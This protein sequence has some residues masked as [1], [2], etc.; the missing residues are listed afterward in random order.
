MW[1]GSLG[2][3]QQ[4]L[5]TQRK[6]Q[7]KYLNKLSNSDGFLL[8]E[9]FKFPSEKEKTNRSQTALAWSSP[10]MCISICSFSLHLSSWQIQSPA[11]LFC[12]EDVLTNP[13]QWPKCVSTLC[14]ESYCAT[15]KG[16]VSSCIFA[17]DNILP[18]FSYF[19][20]FSNLFSWDQTWLLDNFLLENL[21]E[22]NFSV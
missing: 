10:R 8:H 22:I 13:F 5:K 16:D 4:L 15:W 19:T 2:N 12:D 21:T 14:Q 3:K 9:S 17:F 20:V 6:K 1:D 7:L 18:I 11:L